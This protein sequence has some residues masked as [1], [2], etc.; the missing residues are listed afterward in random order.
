MNTSTQF[1]ILMA[2]EMASIPNWIADKDDDKSRLTHVL[3]AYKL[4]PF[5]KEPI[6]DDTIEAIAKDFGTDLGAIILRRPEEDF[7]YL[8]I[9]VW[10][11]PGE[12]TSYND[13]IRDY[14]IYNE[15]LLTLWRDGDEFVWEEVDFSEI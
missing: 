12:G 8:Y 10:V 7:W 6:V 5:I 2:H 4:L 15:T 13:E 1:D 11:K 9:R 14:V 3:A